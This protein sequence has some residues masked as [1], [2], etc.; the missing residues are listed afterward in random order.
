LLPSCR[1]EAEQIDVGE[2]EEEG[3]GLSSSSAP[4]VH[5]IDKQSVIRSSQAD[6]SQ[7]DRRGLLWLLDEESIFPGSSSPPEYIKK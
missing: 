7:T 2:L 1:Y 5:L 6:L 4:L 3:A